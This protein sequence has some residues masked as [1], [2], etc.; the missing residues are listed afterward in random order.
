VTRD[1]DHNVQISTDNRWAELLE[2]S[3][4]PVL[5]DNVAA[6]SAAS[7]SRCLSGAVAWPRTRD[8][9]VVVAVLRCDRSPGRDVTLDLRSRL[10]SK[11]RART[12]G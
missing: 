10:L 1:A 9:Q 7:R 12:R 4:A 2:S 11:R 5:S 6:G 8:Y 3:I